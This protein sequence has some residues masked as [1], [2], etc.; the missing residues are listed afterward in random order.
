MKLVPQSEKRL[1]HSPHYKINLAKVSVDKSIATSKRTAL[2]KNIQ[3]Y[4]N[5]F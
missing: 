2:E 4:I 3:K 1:D 5:I